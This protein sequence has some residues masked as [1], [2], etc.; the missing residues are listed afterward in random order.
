MPGSRRTA[1]AA[2]PRWAGAGRPAVADLR[3]FVAVLALC[4]LFAAGTLAGAPVLRVPAGLLLTFAVPGLLVLR[5]VRA[6][7]PRW[8]AATVGVALSFAVA[9]GAVLLLEATGTAASTAGVGWLLGGLT[10]ALAGADLVARTIRPVPGRPAGDEPAPAAGSGPDGPAPGTPPRAGAGRP[11]RRYV[12]VAAV[13]VFCAAAA[14]TAVTVSVHSER[15][16]AAESFTQVGL[17]P[18]P[19]DPRSFTVSVTNREGTPV[20][21]RLVVTAP[22]TEPVERTVTV[23]AGRTWSDRIT[24]TTA[25]TLEIRVYGG[26]PTAAGHREV[27]AAVL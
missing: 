19:S 23:P 13:A 27:R 5:L 7:M 26:T 6:R 9:L 20:P 21:Y 10:V 14:A 3:V 17:V 1:P 16:T 18:E 22:G 2:D 8:Q 15:V 4:A 24:V 12:P 11:W 25:G